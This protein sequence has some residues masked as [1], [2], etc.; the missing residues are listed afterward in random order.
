MNPMTA[1]ERREFEAL[2]RDWVQ[3]YDCENLNE[4]PLM[5]RLQRLQNKIH[6]RVEQERHDRMMALMQF[7]QTREV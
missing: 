2:R 5:V 3:G 7:F 1:A 4:C 6:R